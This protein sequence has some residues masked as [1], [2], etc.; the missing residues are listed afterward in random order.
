MVTGQE[1]P[2]TDPP[3]HGFGCGQSSAARFAPGNRASA[4]WLVCAV[5]AFNLTRAAA[6]ITGPDL[7]K[8]TTGTIRRTLIA[9]PARIAA[10]A[11]LHGSRPGVGLGTMFKMVGL[12]GRLAE[13]VA[14]LPAYSCP[15]R[16]GAQRVRTCPPHALRRLCRGSTSR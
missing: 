5:I 7:A 12:F 11:H 10:S 2:P 8:A 15:D 9:V 6:T 16:L 4:A 3:G 14:G 1:A 13:E